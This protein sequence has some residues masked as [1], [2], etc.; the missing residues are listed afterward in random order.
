MPL[1]IEDVSGFLGLEVND[2]YGRIAGVLV[3]YYSDV[4][5]NVEGAEIRVNDDK[6]VYVDASR[7]RVEEGKLV[8]LPEW[9]QKAVQIIDAL[10]RALKRKKALEKTLSSSDL[11]GAIIENYLKK[12]KTE[13]K[14]LKEKASKVKA[15]IKVRSNKIDD[16]ILHID[17]ALVNLQIIY[18]AGEI[19][20][21]AYQKSAEY[22]RRSKDWLLKEKNDIRDTL[23][24]I[25]KLESSP[26]L[27]ETPKQTKKS[28]A[29]K[30]AQTFKQAVAD[31]VVEAA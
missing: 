31:L 15:E 20:D 13:I 30:P 22:L 5:G 8:V 6:L 7:L 26:V 2:P 24:Q 21:S 25:E 1:K 19:S 16:E 29:A 3:T 9:K 14:Q 10:G 12:L 23:T 18:L 27:L 17:K 4:D 11:P 28:G